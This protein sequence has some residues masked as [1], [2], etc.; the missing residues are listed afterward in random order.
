[1]RAEVA[2]S[3]TCPDCGGQLHFRIEGF[4]PFTPEE[5]TRLTPETIRV[6][7]LCADRNCP[8]LLGLEPVLE[9]VTLRETGEVDGLTV[10]AERH[11]ERGL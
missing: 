5:L 4:R 10:V 8:D 1:M 9:R 11:L 2:S 7:G 6:L 3:V